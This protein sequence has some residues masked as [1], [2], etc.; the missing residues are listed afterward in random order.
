MSSPFAPKKIGSLTVDNG[1]FLSPMSMFSAVDGVLSDFH[2]QHYLQFAD[3]GLGGIIIEATAV[4]PEGRVTPACLGLYDMTQA[5][6]L[7][8]LV[9][10]LKA[11]T[12]AKIGVQLAHAGARGSRVVDWNRRPIE[13]LPLSQGGW[14][15]VGPPYRGKKRW[16]PDTDSKGK[17]ILDYQTAAIKA[18]QFGGVDFL[19]I[20]LAHNYL[21]H[22]CIATGDFET[23]VRIVEVIQGCL[24]DVPIGIRLSHGYGTPA[25]VVE[26]H[27]CLQRF[28]L[29]QNIDI[30]ARVVR[31]VISKV[32]LAYVT[33]T[34]GGLERMLGWKEQSALSLSVQRIS[35]SYPSIPIMVSG[36]ITSLADCEQFPDDS[37]FAIGRPLLRNP[38]FLSESKRPMP[39][40]R[41]IPRQ[42][43]RAYPDINR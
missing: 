21:L 25:E 3:S 32:P 29:M 18:K 13:S 20:H 5:V 24:S 16:Q 37:L 12:N 4:S 15:P 26:D 40:L 39:H 31:E 42:Y 22:H 27:T 28:A 1:F 9:R 11:K 33:I 43:L 10:N 14:V 34:S 7:Q 36:G 2:R 35:E 8:S 41:S 30:N 6:E 19:E 23:P 38:N 17:I